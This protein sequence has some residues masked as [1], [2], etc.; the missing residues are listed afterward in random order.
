MAF[1]QSKE[2]LRVY[3]NKYKPLLVNKTGCTNL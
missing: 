2:I 3:K 1:Q